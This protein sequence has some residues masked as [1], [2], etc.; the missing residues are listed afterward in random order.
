MSSGVKP[1]ITG[2]LTKAKKALSLDRSLLRMKEQNGDAFTYNFEL[3]Y[4]VLF[5]IAESYTLNEMYAE[6]LSTYSLITKNKKFPNVNR[7]KL[8]VGNIYFKL[9]KFSKA[10]K[11]Y[12]MA[13]D[14][15]P[16]NQTELRLKITHN[17]GILF[18]KMGQYSDAAIRFEFIMS[19]KG[20]W[21]TG[22]HLIL[23]YYAIGDAIGMRRAFQ[24]L[25]E[26]AEHL[27]EDE[28]DDKTVNDAFKRDELYVYENKI[29]KLA[30]KNILMAA[31]LIASLIEDDFNEGYNWCLDVI[32][33]S[34]Y[35][36]LASELDFNK[37]VMF[38][39]QSDSNQAIE[40]LKYFEKK[41]SPIATNA[42]I[43]LSFI[44]LLVSYFFCYIF[45]DG[46]S[47]LSN[48][49]NYPFTEGP[50]RHQLQL[51]FFMW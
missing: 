29:R 16:R 9:G 32:K 27:N 22:L 30:E 3:T 12:K 37:A 38:L 46:L 26:N 23:C 34:A 50:R 15:V 33:N 8:N 10:I 24:L 51:I 14:Q 49:Y 39:R 2:G 42:V 28:N 47:L 20:D 13:L 36:K 1:D 21:K 40:S 5:N 4:S 41:E 17:I 7:L 11:M 35:S 25:L 19:E 48:A 18:I 44:Y 6:A 31:N 43:N 45:N